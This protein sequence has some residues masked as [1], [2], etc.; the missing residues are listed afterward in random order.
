MVVGRSREETE[1]RDPLGQDRTDKTS[2]PKMALPVV[3]EQERRTCLK[4]FGFVQIRDA[5]ILA[6]LLQF[7]LPPRIE[8]P[9]S[10]HT[11]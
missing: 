6:L 9:E 5:Q 4:D 1:F 3:H 11:L 8:V 2:L 10:Q 7:R